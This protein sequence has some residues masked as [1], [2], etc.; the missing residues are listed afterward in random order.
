VTLYVVIPLLLLVSI[1]QTALI[2]YLSI[3]GIFADLPL[4]FV[5]SWGLLE[6]KRQGLLW[7]IIAGMS[8]DILSGAPFG[9]AT[10]SLGLVGFLVGLGQA[11]VFRYH[12]A[13]SLVAI[14]LA[15]ILYS[16]VFLSIVSILGQS[17][18]W[19][20]SML[21]IVQPSAVL[22]ALLLPLVFFPLRLVHQRFMKQE[23]AV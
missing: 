15:T 21:R 23:M 12:V 9:A 8:I 14:F 20:D 3:W 18:D 16:I 17:V 2:P 6:G 19:L 1:L 10:L 7:G 13:L 22:N 5:I 4:L 11:T